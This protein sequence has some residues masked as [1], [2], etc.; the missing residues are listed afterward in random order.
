M[1]GYGE[2]HYSNRKT[3]NNAILCTVLRDSGDKWGFCIHQYFCRTIG[4]YAISLDA[5]GCNVKD[6]QREAFAHA[7][8]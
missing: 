1:S 3:S 7:E 8:H 4:K 6:K 2:C 5:A